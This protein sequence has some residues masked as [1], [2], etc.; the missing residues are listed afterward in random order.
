MVRRRDLLAGLGAAGVAGLAGCLDAVPT[1]GETTLGWFAIYN[2]DEA[3]G[4]RFEARVERDGD[5]AHEST[6]EVAAHDPESESN[7][8]PNAVLPCTWAHVPGDYVVSVR[9]AGGAW[10]RF[11]LVAGALRPPDCVVAFVRH[12]DDFGP[13]DDPP[14]FEFVLD[15]T[16]CAEVAS[17]AGG[18]EAAADPS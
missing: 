2:Y 9:R 6:H 8:P 7:S 12:G 3:R 10:N 15:E 13:S 18:C 14:A 16:D 1:V 5:V 4:Y 11:D 17:L